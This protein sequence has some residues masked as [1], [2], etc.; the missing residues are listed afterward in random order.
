METQALTQADPILLAGSPVD[1]NILTWMERFL[2]VCRSR[3]LAQGTLEFYIKKLKGFT[4]F[5]GSLSIEN[6]RQ[7]TP[8]TIREFLV[9]LEEKGHKA[10]GVHCHYRAIRTL[11]P[12]YEFE[13]EPDDWENPIRGVKAPIVPLEP[14]DPVSI[15]TIQLLIGTC[16]TDSLTNFR[17]HSILLFLLD[18]GV[19]MPELLSLN[20]EDVDI[21][22]GT[23]IIR[24]GKGRKPRN[25]Y[26]GDRSRQL[27][28]R[29]LKQRQDFDPALLITKSGTRLKQNGLQMM[30]R[31]RSAQADISAP[32]PHDFR[33]AF[34]LERRQAG[35]DILR[36]S[37]LMGHTSLQVLNRYLKQ[38]GEDLERAAKMSSPVDLN[39]RRQE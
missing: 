5:R 21:F 26:L 4:G 25:V 13:V 16:K 38:A 39:C 31:R 22:T 28:R 15:E 11:L 7:I 33:R 19:R 34:A 9:F 32:S 23:V 14:L 30:L 24:S 27:L 8:D 37:K 35:V 17:D 1:G 20:K 12:W 18:T 29:Y 2:R 36:I 3:N 6:I 10:A